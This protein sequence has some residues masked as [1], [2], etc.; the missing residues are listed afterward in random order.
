MSKALFL[1]LLF[2]TSAM[3]ATT[4]VHIVHI[5]D[6]LTKDKAGCTQY[7]VDTL[8]GAL[9]TLDAADAAD[10]A[11]Y[12]G[13]YEELETVMVNAGVSS[14][15]A[16]AAVEELTEIH[17]E[18]FNYPS[19]Q[20]TAAVFDDL[21]KSKHLLVCTVS[22]DCSLAHQ[23]QNHMLF[24]DQNE[25]IVLFPPPKNS[26]GEFAINFYSTIASSAA[27]RIL[28]HWL[29]AGFERQ[30]QVA[31]SADQY[32]KWFSKYDGGPLRPD[33][34]DQGFVVTFMSL[35]QAQVAND[36]F[37]IVAPVQA[38]Q[39]AL[40]MA[41]VTYQDLMHGTNRNL[42]APIMGKLRITE[43]NFFTKTN[44]ILKAM[45]ATILASSR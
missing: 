45:T 36:L 10:A 30:R 3:A 27:E 23:S 17:A 20:I 1:G 21:I 19:L 5:S 29:Q 13:K 4:T 8:H 16:K 37:S 12:L 18:S 42:T 33:I 43:E 44:E 22:T 11:V 9:Q 28:V 24:T 31:G 40:H 32:Y 41:K 14:A 39:N 7:L 25:G 35:Y 34:L 38:R 15:L 6:E 26:V 2:S